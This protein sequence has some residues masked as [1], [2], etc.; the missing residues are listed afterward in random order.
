MNNIKSICVFSGSK[1]GRSKKYSDSAI[2]LG[3][4]IADRRIQL[5]YGGGREGLMGTIANA[6][7]RSGGDVTGIITKHLQDLEIGHDGLT[8]LYV[9]DT[10]H[11]RKQLMFELA[12]AF[13]AL[14]G[15]IGTLDEVFEIITWRHLRLHSKPIVIVNENGYWRPLKKLLNAIVAG[16]FANP[17]ITE[18]YSLVDDTSQVFDVLTKSDK[19]KLSSS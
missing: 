6:A 10:M 2:R 3:E 5:I 13:V 16:G 19:H 11:K 15:G 7:L 1:F 9:V 4:E 8:T 18:S 14:P 12:D 17:H